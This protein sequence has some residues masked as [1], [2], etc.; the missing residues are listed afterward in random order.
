MPNVFTTPVAA[1]HAANLF[2]RSRPCNRSV[3]DV[4][5]VRAI[6]PSM[7]SRQLALWGLDRSLLHCCH[8]V[9]YQPQTG[10]MEVREL[11]SLIS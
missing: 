1:A 4:L 9:L 6:G 5:A 8:A 10:D 7:R 11:L 3:G 2:L